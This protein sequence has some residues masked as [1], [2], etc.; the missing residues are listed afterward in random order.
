MS[1]STMSLVI[2]V[3]GIKTDAQFLQTLQNNVR[4]RRTMNK[5]VIDSATSE[6]SKAVQNYLRWIVIDDWQSEPYWQNQNPTERR[7][8][9]I[10]R[11]ANKILDKTSAPDDL[12]LLAL[13][14]AFLVYNHAAVKSL[15]WKTPISV[16]TSITLGISVLWRFA[17]YEVMYFK[18]DEPSL[19]SESQETLGRILGTAEHVGHVLDLQNSWSVHK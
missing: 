12:W 16:L 9:D 5:L 14:Y 1:F 7:Y 11:L 18:N 19:S 8:Q 10:K 15:N 4:K 3:Y 2:D 17:F 13:W 6:T